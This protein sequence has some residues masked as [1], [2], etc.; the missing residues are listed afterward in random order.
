MPEPRRRRY[1]I[2]AHKI[3]HAHRDVA[4][5]AMPNPAAT[6]ARGYRSILGADTPDDDDAFPL[7][8]AV[9]YSLE[10]TDAEA[11]A[12]AAASN[13]RYI[14]ED[15][16]HSP[17]RAVARPTGTPPIPTLQTLTYMRERYVD[18]RRWHGRD[19]PVAVLDQGTTAAVR[20]VMGWTLVARTVTGGAQLGGRDLYRD[21]YD[22]GCLVAPNAVP[23]GGL[24]LDCVIIEEDGSAFTSAEA[25]GITWA[26]DNGAKVIN[27]SFGGL[28]G[29]VPQVFIDAADYAATAGVQ[30][31]LSAGNDNLAD[32]GVPSSLSRTKTNVH[33]S[34]AFDESTDRRGLFS[35]HA[36]DASGC[37]PGVDV[38]SLDIY[39][40][41]TRWNGTSAS[42]P[43][44]AQLI[45]RGATGGTFTAAQVAAALRAN[46]RDTGAGAAEQGAGAWDLQRA[47]AALG[48]VPATPTTGGAATVNHVDTQGG[49]ALTGGYNVATPAGIQADDMRVVVLAS[50]SGGRT[51]A[52]P[53][54]VTLVDANYQALWE[55][56]AG[57]TVGPTRVRVL[58]KPYTAGEPSPSLFTFGG[59]DWFSAIGAMTVRGAGGLDSERFA[60][61]TRFGTGGTLVTLPVL[62]AT[63]NDLLVCV[64]TQR[65]PTATTATLSL[66]TG[67]TQ[68][69]FF[70]PTSGTT[71]YSLLLATAQLASGARTAAYTSTSNDSTG[72]WA[73][74]AFTIPAADPAI[75]PV[76][77]TEPGGPDN[78]LLPFL[79]RS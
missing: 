42:A 35:N 24:L 56:G 77:Q 64:F 46:T 67:L 3:A 6:Q 8:S 9:A 34:I 75:T 43:H 20:A 76:V 49:A 32:L 18:L 23:A 70:R 13:V 28:P 59:G 33:S 11:E 65:H 26:V 62:P 61:H 31:V 25:A 4:R 16:R 29:T 57:Q 44:M 63:T 72:T 53:G 40:N 48:A 10:L 14:E 73:T 15:Q 78:A 71:G 36:S 7:G 68:R 27:M 21:D 5:T 2:G 30:I 47:L 17:H 45:A 22:H 1:N 79:P 60:P 38:L 12:F 66:P 41:P 51:A 54:W 37:A 69:G 39:G 19:V 58:A 52:P 55:L 74:V 50:S